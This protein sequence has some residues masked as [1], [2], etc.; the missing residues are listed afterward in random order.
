LP[1]AIFMGYGAA[2]YFPL[3]SVKPVMLGAR[4]EAVAWGISLA[5][6]LSSIF[7][8]QSLA[9]RRMRRLP[10]AGRAVLI[11]ALP[12]G[13]AAAWI[14]I[15]SNAHWSRY[16]SDPLPYFAVKLAEVL[17]ASPVLLGIVLVIPLAGLCWLAERAFCEME[18][19]STRTVGESYM[20][21][22]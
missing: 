9:W 8:F 17:P 15:P 4:I 14:M 16:G 11:A 7:L 5:L 10:M 13:V 12:V 22:S 6:L 2:V 18:Y 19:S 3:G 21:R 1:I 20:Q